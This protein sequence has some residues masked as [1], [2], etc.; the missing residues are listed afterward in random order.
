M[1]KTPHVTESMTPAEHVFAW[2]RSLCDPGYANLS[3]L[4]CYH[5][6][7]VKTEGIGEACLDCF[8]PIYRLHGMK[9]YITSYKAAME[10]ALINGASPNDIDGLTKSAFLFTGVT[11]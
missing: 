2:L 7:T 5:R 3:P 9:P 1:S 11:E 6:R 10:R 8:A 4:V